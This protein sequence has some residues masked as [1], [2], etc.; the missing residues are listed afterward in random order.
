M[1]VPKEEA[2]NDFPVMLIG[3]VIRR[4]V[5]PQT[6]GYGVQWLRC[7]TKKGMQAIYHFIASYPEFSQMTLPFAD[8]EVMKAPVVGY[9]FQTN[10]FYIPAIPNKGAP[11]PPSPFAGDQVK[12]PRLARVEPSASFAR[13]KED[14]AVTKALRVMNEQVHVSIATTLI[15]DGEEYFGTVIMLSLTTLFV[16]TSA[17]LEV[18]ELVRVRLPVNL[19]ERQTVVD[20]LCIVDSHGPHAALVGGSGV[21]LSVKAVDE[22]KRAGLFERYVKYLYYQMLTTR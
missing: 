17:T 18:G 13:S 14:G 11:I 21:H 9:D 22:S 6:P 7:L 2:A 8:N 5:A 3:R 20:L 1:L 12:P 19:S 16:V 10:S 15:M 4:Q